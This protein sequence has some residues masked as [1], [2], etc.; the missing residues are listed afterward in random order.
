MEIEMNG[1]LL[2][3]GDLVPSRLFGRF[4]IRIE[5]SQVFDTRAFAR[6]AYHDRLDH[7]PRLGQMFGLDCAQVKHVAQSRNDRLSGALADERTTR[8]ALLKTQQAG[9]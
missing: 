6:G 3:K 4:D 9:I 2:V 8:S 5:R 1:G 7:H